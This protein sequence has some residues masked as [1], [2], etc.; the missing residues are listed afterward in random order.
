[1]TGARLVL[2]VRSS[3][4]IRARIFL[5]FSSRYWLNRRCKLALI[6][7]CVQNVSVDD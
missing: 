4:E 6:V 5:K 7:F 1:V 2:L 3:E